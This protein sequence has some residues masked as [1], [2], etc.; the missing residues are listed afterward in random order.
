VLSRKENR[1]VLTYLWNMSHS[2]DLILLLGVFVNGP[3]KPH[4]KSD[5]KAKMWY[6]TSCPM[7]LVTV[8]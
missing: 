5:D 7:H 4:R 8:K 3:Q 6:N 2:N 1:C